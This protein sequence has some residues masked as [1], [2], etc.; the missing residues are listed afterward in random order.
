MDKLKLREK[1]KQLRNSLNSDLK[2][3]YDQKLLEV[4]SSLDIAPFNNFF[5]YNSFKSE[6][7]T[8]KIVQYLFKEDKNV[9]LPK[10]IGRD[11]FFIK[12]EG[13]ALIKNSLGIYEPQGE[14]TNQ[15]PDICILP[16][17]ATDLNGNRLGYGGGYYDRFLKDENCIKAGLLYSFQIAD[18][19]PVYKTDIKLDILITENKIIR[20]NN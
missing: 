15:K 1:Y 7:D 19:L 10:I 18:M 12:Y 17:L 11:M 5:I 13:Q 14:K 16:L 9:F 20:I 4:F 2:N 8:K 6:V 3:I